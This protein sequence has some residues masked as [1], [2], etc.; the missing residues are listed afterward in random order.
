MDHKSHQPNCLSTSGLTRNWSLLL[1]ALSK[2]FLNTDR[3]GASTSS[4]GSLFQYLT[5]LSIKKCFLIFSLKLGIQIGVLLLRKQTFN[6]K[7]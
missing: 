6:V 2:C 4:L 3:R 5:S 1:R 7:Y